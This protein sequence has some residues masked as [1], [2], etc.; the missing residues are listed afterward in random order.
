MTTTVTTT[1]PPAVGPGP[2]PRPPAPRRARL[3]A[4]Q[5][6]PH[7]AMT[8]V[9]GLVFTIACGL[10]IMPFVAI[11][12]TS[13]A[14]AE[15]IAGSGGLVLLPESLNLEAYAAILSGGVVTRAL[16]ISALVTLGGT[17]LSLTVSTAFAYA[18]T[19]RYLPGRRGWTMLL[20]VSLFFGPGLIPSYLTVQQFGL[21]DSLWALIVPTA[22][23]SFNVI[24]LRA[25]F[26][27]L[28][29]DLLEAAELDGASEARIFAFIVLPLSKAA[30]AVIGLFYAVGFWNSFFNALLYINRTELWP[31]QLVLRTYVVNDN[32]IDTA[33]L[34]TDVLPAQ[35]ALQMAIL[36]ISIVPIL[37]VYPFLQ[38]HFAK[39]ALTGAIKG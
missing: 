22:V 6:R 27:G 35:P 23:N 13:L 20:I 4:G 14:P 19:R 1:R 12:S 26:G 8:A 34:A 21:L 33:A 9:K 38:R 17:L 28:P 18:L 5:P 10:V 16:G 7:P 29:S 30:L 11:V 39:G 3:V 31:L 37:C 36:V 2:A 32:Q 24:V 25:F 15:Q